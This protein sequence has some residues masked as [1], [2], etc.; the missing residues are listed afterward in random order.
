MNF[1]LI[2]PSMDTEILKVNHG[3][4]AKCLWRLTLFSHFNIIHFK[5]RMKLK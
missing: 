5:K 4:S 1:K 3:H 2:S